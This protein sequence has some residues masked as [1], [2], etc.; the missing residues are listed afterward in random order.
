MA[1]NVKF[2]IVAIFVVILVCLYGIVGIPKS[3]D[4]LVANWKRNIHLGL[5]LRGGSQL[6]L[7]VQIQDAFKAEADGVIQR[8]RDELTK[9]KVGFG[10]MMRNDPDSLQTADKIQIDIKG[11]PA[12]QAGNFRQVVNDN[13]GGV[14][15]LTPVNPTDFRMTMK[16]SEALKLRQDTLTQ[17]MHTIE[18][19]INALGLAESS[20]Q[21]RG[22]SDADAELLVQLPGV[23][24]P[25][26]VKQ[27][28]KTAAMLELYSVMG[29]PFASREEG[30]VA[31]E[32]GVLPLNSQLLSS[33]AKG[34]AP[35]R[36]LLI[37]AHAGG[38]GV[39]ICATPAPRRARAASGK[40]TSC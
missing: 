17:S 4:E 9:A 14:W 15:N 35:G 34:G 3:T 21:Q 1:N 37:G 16:P 13:F 7:Q 33:Q 24:D 11:V 26:R 2:K 6:V 22:R 20:V 5:D 8:M 39:A 27:I 10:E 19:K 29:G 36:N 38:N 30:D 28:L 25:A 31:D 18:K 32:G 12:T 40:R 23:D